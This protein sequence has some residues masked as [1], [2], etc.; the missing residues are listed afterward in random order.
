MGKTMQDTVS[1]VK[2]TIYGHGRGWCFTLNDF[3]SLG[4]SQAVRKALSRLEKADFIHRI[5]WGLYEYPRKH[6]TLGQLPPDINQVVKAVARKNQIK[7]L[8]SGAYAANLLGL[9]EQVPGKVV[10]LTD[11]PSRKIKIGKTELI[12]KN[13]AP[14]NMAPAGTPAGLV[15]Q[16]LRYLGKDHV[17][18]VVITKLKKRLSKTDR[19]SLR[20]HSM[21]APEWVRKVID[22][23]SESAKSNG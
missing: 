11:G 20:K 19:Q 6:A 10:H 9:S 4:S 2:F 8:P 13:T 5:G 7:V 21:L 14:K 23:L 15:I 17:D 22:R 18:D 3:A 16:A 12:F 1:T